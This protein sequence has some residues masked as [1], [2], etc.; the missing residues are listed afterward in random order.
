MSFLRNTDIKK[1]LGRNVPRFSNNS[2]TAPEAELPTKTSTVGTVPAAMSNTT[3]E[4]TK[5]ESV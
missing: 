5:A 3:Q 4:T 2:P 1:H